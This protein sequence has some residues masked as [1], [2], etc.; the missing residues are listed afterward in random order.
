VTATE[1]PNL[2][3]ALTQTGDRRPAAGPSRGSVADDE[4]D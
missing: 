2:G 3:L 1:D 4:I